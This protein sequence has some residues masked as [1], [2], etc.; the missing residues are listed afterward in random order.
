[1]VV[2]SMV[3]TS[4]PFADRMALTVMG[5]SLFAPAAS[6]STTRRLRGML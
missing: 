6:H 1:L 2:G 5:R 3:R 4:V